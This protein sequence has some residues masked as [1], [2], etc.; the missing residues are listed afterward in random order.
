[1]GK[2]RILADH[3]INRIAA[4]EV[5]ERPAS[6]VKELL[7]NSLDAGATAIE[8]QLTGGG[9]K[10]IRVGDDGAGMDRDDALLSLERHATSKLLRFEDLDAI[11]TFGFRG[12]ALPSIAAVSRLLVRTAARDGEGTEIEARGGRIVAVRPVGSARGTW[13]EVGSLFFN[14]P[15]RRKFLRADSTELAHV[16]RVASRCGLAHPGLRLTVSSEGRTLLDLPGAG[17]R[18]ERVAQVFGPEAARSLVTFAAERRGARAHGFAGRPTQTRPRGDAQHFF[19]NGRLVQDRT[20][21]HAVAEAYGNTVPHGRFPVLV[22]FL[23]LDPGRVDVNVHPQKSEVRFADPGGIHDLVR[24]AVASALGRSAVV[25][26]LSDLNGSAGADRLSAVAEAAHRYLDRAGDL[27]AFA[28]CDGPGTRLEARSES[29]G[30]PT[31][32]SSALAPHASGDASEA[33]A[34]R[35][36]GTGRARLVPLAQLR[37]SYVLAEDADGLVIVDQHAAH[38]RVLFERYLAAVEADRVEI[39]KLLFPRTIELPAEDRLLLEEEAEEFRRLGFL[40]EPF[41]ADAVRVDG[42]PALAAEVEPYS[43]LRELLGEA[44]RARSTVSAVG[45]LRRRLVTSAACQA[46]IKVNHS[47]GQAAMQNLLD[48][49]ARAQSPT[50]CPHG[51]PV[52]FRLTLRDIERAFRRR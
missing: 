37:S 6:V 51:R 44:A 1:M 30:A 19:V 4:G 13:I 15:A 10:Q 42:I 5:V 45:S 43:L 14:V 9:K 23:D 27:P 7:E 21:A 26:S 40:V 29:A 39:Q 52:L 28:R 32:P 2:I 50:T 16:V 31:L 35:D 47:L 34:P 36:L 25:P 8:V 41:G 38:E 48:D 24:E 18:A 20:L 12:E 17:T 3:V 33:A 22:L 11:G 49:L 46:A